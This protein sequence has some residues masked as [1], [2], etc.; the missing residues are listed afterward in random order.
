MVTKSL[1]PRVWASNPTAVIAVDI[2][3][4][5]IID[6]LSNSD[7]Y[8]MIISIT[9]SFTAFLL[10]HLSLKL[11]VKVTV[12]TFA[13]YAGSIKY[14][15]TTPLPWHGSFIGFSHQLRLIRIFCQLDIDLWG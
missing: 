2:N 12:P 15:Y 3:L 5:L 7:V 6:E 8:M 10:I 14:L 9:N 4:Q 1:W 11:L 13:C